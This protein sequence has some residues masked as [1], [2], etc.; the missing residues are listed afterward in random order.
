MT[1]IIV[2]IGGAALLAATLL[3]TLSVAGRHVG[4]P[5]HGVIE[6]IQ[7]AV[8]VAGGLGLVASA[9][10]GNQARVRLVLD[11]LPPRANALARRFS[12]LLAAA[13]FAGLLAGS[14]WIAFDLWDGYERSEL[15]GVPW[16]WLR[17]FANLCLAALVLLSLRAA[18][19]R[20]RR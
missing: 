20:A 19:G 15:L 3:D 8:L 13:F 5:F 14:G 1:R 4:L 18:F 7:A 16:R 10:A 17:V 12:A 6:L 2:W 9:L 11:R